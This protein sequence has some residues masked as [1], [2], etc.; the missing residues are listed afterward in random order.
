MTH[1]PSIFRTGLLATTIATTLA[2]AACGS[3]PM[4]MPSAMTMATQTFRAT[5]SSAAEVPPNSSPATGTFQATFDKSSSVLKWRVM[6]SGLTGPATMA[7]FHGPALPGAN[8]GV[9]VPFPSAASPAEG[10]ATLTPA[11]ITDLMGGKWYV[12]IHT[13][14][15]PGG[16]I[17][18]QVM[19][20]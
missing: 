6:Y 2:I 10:S 19:M 18:G 12:N 1:L 8:A 15:H 20:N 4:Q 17:R 11:Q 9:V 14:Q 7:H 3:A 13:A 16:E 5:L